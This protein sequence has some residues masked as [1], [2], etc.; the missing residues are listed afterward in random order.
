MV[1]F[2]HEPFFNDI[3]KKLKYIP[4]LTNQHEQRADRTFLVSANAPGALPSAPHPREGGRG[5]GGG[6]FHPLIC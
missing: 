5:E 6:S 1:S 3:K 2:K 4:T